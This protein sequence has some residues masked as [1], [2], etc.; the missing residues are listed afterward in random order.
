MR[1]SSA[2]SDTI[3]WITHALEITSA[4]AKTTK[5]ASQVELDSKVSTATSPRG[6]DRS[7][8]STAAVS[9]AIPDLA[10]IEQE[11]RLFGPTIS[12]SSSIPDMKNLEGHSSKEDTGTSTE[13]YNTISLISHAGGKTDSPMSTIAVSP[14]VTEIMRP[15]FTSS[16]RR[17]HTRNPIHQGQSVTT[18]WITHPGTEATSRVLTTTISPNNQEVEISKSVN[19]SPKLQNSTS[20]ITDGEKQ[21]SFTMSTLAGSLGVIEGTPSPVINRGTERNSRTETRDFFPRSARD[22]KLLDH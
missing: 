9:S 18:S 20:L 7:T 15:L 13:P 22:H 3:S 8:I 16:G 14:D 6:K 10:S 17:I 19:P 4:I 5:N 12:I 1:V 11:D 2:E 21:P